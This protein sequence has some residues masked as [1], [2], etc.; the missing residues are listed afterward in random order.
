MKIDVM[1]SGTSTK[2]M[3]VGDAFTPVWMLRTDV[4]TP[5]WGGIQILSNDYV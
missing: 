4:Q 3:G 1:P 5:V 2:K